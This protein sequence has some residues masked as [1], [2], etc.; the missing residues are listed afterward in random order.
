MWDHNTIDCKIN[1]F[2]FRLKSPLQYQKIFSKFSAERGKC[3]P[4][5]CLYG[6]FFHTYF[7]ERE[8]F[9]KSPLAKASNTLPLVP[10]PEDNKV[11]CIS[12]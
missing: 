7:F 1:I 6:Q 10:A 8:L 5:P 11:I 9:T 12:Y 4:A 3:A 2:I